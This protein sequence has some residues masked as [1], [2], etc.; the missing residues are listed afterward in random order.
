M[1]TKIEMINAGIKQIKL[2]VTLIGVYCSCYAQNNSMPANAM[3]E[4]SSSKLKLN[5]FLDTAGW[6]LNKIAVGGR[7]LA[8][9]AG[10]YTILYSSWEPKEDLVRLNHD[11]RAYMFYPREAKTQGDSLIRF[12]EQQSIGVIEAIWRMD[13]KNPTDILVMITLKAKKDGYYSIASPTLSRIKEQ[14]LSWGM[15]PGNWYGKQIQSDLSLSTKYSM[16]LPY[17][18][19]LGSEKSTMTLSPMISTKQGITL[20]VIPAPGTAADPW[21]KDKKIRTEN[22][23][24][25]STMDRFQELTPVAYAPVLGHTGSKL[26]TGDTISFSFRY[27]LMRSDWFSV[28]RHAAEDVYHFSDL[29]KIQQQK[30][31]LTERLRLMQLRLRDDKASL[32]NTWKYDGMEMGA[33][34]SKNADIGAMWMLAHTTS[35][36]IMQRHLPYVRNFKLAQ[37]Q[38]QPGFFQYTA[39]GEYG[40]KDGF[41]SEMGNWVEPLFTTYY[42]LIDMGNILLF[43]PNDQLLKDRLKLAADKMLSWQHTD[44][45]WDVAYDKISHKLTYPQL[46]DLR[47]TWYGMLVAYRILKDKRYLH[48]AEKGANWLIENGIDKGFYLGVCGDAQ[49]ILDFGVAQT[50]QSLLDLYD[51]TKREHYKTAA[52]EAARVYATT[53]FTHPAATSKTKFVNGIKY[54]DWEINQ[55]GLSVE[56]PQGSAGGSGPILIPSFAGLYVRIY[57]LTRDSLFLDMSRAAVRGRHAFM[58]PNSGQSV[59]YWSAVDKVN[60]MVMFFPHQSYWQIGWITDYLLAE[61][62][63][64]S[65]GK[66]NF[67]R[68]FM[69]PKVGPHQTYGFA[70]GTIFGQQASLWMQPGLLV[71]S[72]PNLE[73]IA[74]VSKSDKKLYLITLNQSHLE[75]CGNLEL[76]QEMLPAKLRAKVGTARVL[77]GSKTGFSSSPGIMN[78]KIPAWEISVIAIDLK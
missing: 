31:A 58:D 57:E 56:H 15:L 48:A 30:V 14:D 27:S 28:F 71:S 3:L 34:G 13:P 20:A 18:P 45:S 22:K 60:S 66:V 23:V 9:A 25:M 64:R 19:I 62:H 75:Q 47:P 53:I 55:T 61:V 77:Q 51:I 72:N 33:N 70:P 68:G 17:M 35:D 38:M 50:A 46:K 49:N 32:W 12:R 16:G 74:A 37:Q 65:G 41:S 21:P 11:G 78:L 1:K 29:L 10:Y 44:G 40:G 24:A 7:E 36:T 39:L 59:Y 63:L 26:K 52:I 2:S 76:Y 42:T 5:W 6:K 67:P 43:N 54:Q 4:L 8:D 73:T 69:T